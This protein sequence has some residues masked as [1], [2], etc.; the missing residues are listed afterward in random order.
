[1]VVDAHHLLHHDRRGRLA[2]RDLLGRSALRFAFAV[3]SSDASGSIYIWAAEAGGRRF[4]RFFGFVVALWTTTVRLCLRARLTYRPGRALSPRSP[5]RRPTSCSGASITL[6]ALTSQRAGHLRDRLPRR[7]DDRQ[8]QLP[9]AL[10]GLLGRVP[11][12]RH[13]GQLLA[14]TRLRLRLPHRLCRHH[15]R[16]APHL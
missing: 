2:R 13:R 7:R 3:R 5:S 1:M 11:R 16:R 14:P 6:S 4:G 12:A 10:M 15:A 8:H 9:R